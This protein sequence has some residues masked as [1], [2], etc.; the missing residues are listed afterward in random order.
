LLFY[1]KKP[2]DPVLLK[3]RKVQP[4][5]KCPNRFHLLRK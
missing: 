3:S 5:K 2:T 4:L 1:M